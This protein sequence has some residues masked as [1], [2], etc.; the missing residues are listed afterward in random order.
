[1]SRMISSGE[2]IQN[3]GEAQR[4][5]EEGPV[6]IT[7]GGAPAFVLFVLLEYDAY[8]RLAGERAGSIVEML[9]QDG[10]DFG[11]DPPRLGDEF[12]WVAKSD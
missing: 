11:F 12:A 8:R 6:V 9:R 3:P 10:G 2:F 1:M 5:A 4:A 7:D